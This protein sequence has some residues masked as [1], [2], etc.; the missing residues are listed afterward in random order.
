MRAAS[1]PRRAQAGCRYPPHPRPWHLWRTDHGTSRPRRRPADLAPCGIPTSRPPP[2]RR[3]A[4]A[5]GRNTDMTMRQRTVSLQTVL[6][7]SEPATMRSGHV[8]PMRPCFVNPGFGTSTRH[9]APGRLGLMR[10]NRLSQRFSPART[11]HSSRDKI[12]AFAGRPLRFRPRVRRAR[13]SPDRSHTRT[14]WAR[15]CNLKELHNG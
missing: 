15:T 5:I 1:T 4:P 9:T 14:R 10:R 7:M 2:C 6:T 12:A 11:A 13:P 3:L 8:R